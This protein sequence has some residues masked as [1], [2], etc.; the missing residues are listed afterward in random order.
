[1][2]KSVAQAGLL[3]RFDDLFQR[4]L[5]LVGILSA[6]LCGQ[7][8]LITDSDTMGIGNDGRMTVNIRKDQVGGLA[9]DAGQLEQFIH[10][11]GNFTTVL[12]QQHDRGIF[13]IVCLGAEQAARLDDGAQILQ[14]GRCQRFQGRVTV[15]KHGGHQID[16]SIGT[17][18][19]KTGG[20]QK[21]VVLLCFQRAGVGIMLLQNA[22]H[23][24]TFFFLCHGITPCLQKINN[25]II[26]EDCKYRKGCL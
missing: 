7:S 23:L 3:L 16:P 21:L 2:Y 26:A 24:G 22:N 1:M 25:Q 9:A 11:I 8:Q 19:R 12:F 4:H 14:I 10:G 5:H 20:K 13:Y 6:V 18:G 15:I 17:L